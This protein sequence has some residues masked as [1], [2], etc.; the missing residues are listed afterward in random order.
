VRS[1][2]D[3]L[4][5]REELTELLNRELLT[6][7]RYNDLTVYSQVV[8]QWPPPVAAKWKLLMLRL[9]PGGARLG[10]NSE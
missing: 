7:D 5:D 2:A 10:P 9:A 4:R 6:M 8:G 3:W 1:L